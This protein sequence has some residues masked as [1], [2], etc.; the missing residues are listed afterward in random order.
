MRVD[1]R[2]FLDG[3]QNVNEAMQI[4]QTRAED[5]A[6]YANEVAQ[7]YNEDVQ[8]MS[9]SEM[10]VEDLE[11][12][13]DRLSQTAK[14][15]INQRIDETTQWLKKTMV[16]IIQVLNFKEPDTRRLRD[17][18]EETVFSMERILGIV[19]NYIKEVAGKVYEGIVTLLHATKQ[20]V[21][22]VQKSVEDTLSMIF[23][24]FQD[25]QVP[26]HNGMVRLDYKAL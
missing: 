21:R 3:P 24:F 19:L 15:K 10:A 14:E 9:D 8:K 1:G 5:N 6:K 20:V 16:R 13:L 12:E 18:A 4:I 22:K 23:Q 25:M 11:K 7:E 17:C 26:K 2:R